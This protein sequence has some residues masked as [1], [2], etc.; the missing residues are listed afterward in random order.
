[1]IIINFNTFF[2]E[3][4]IENILIDVFFVQRDVRVVRLKVHALYALM[5]AFVRFLYAM[6]M[7]TLAVSD[8]NKDCKLNL[9]LII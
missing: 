8:K 6:N 3:K 2:L 9:I 4:N 5:Y 7:A 1:L